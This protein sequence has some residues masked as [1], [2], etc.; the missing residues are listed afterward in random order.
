MVRKSKEEDLLFRI[1]EVFDQRTV[2]T[3]TIAYGL[4]QQDYHVQQRVM[5]LVLEL[6]NLWRI[7]CDPELLRI[8]PNHPLRFIYQAADRMLTAL[9]AEPVRSIEDTGPIPVVEA[10]EGMVERLP[11][12]SRRQA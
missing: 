8:Y 6:L 1:A 7:D 9:D 10:V 11:K 4:Q 3:S 12:N 5:D 2:D